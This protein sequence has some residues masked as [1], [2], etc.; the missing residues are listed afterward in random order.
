MVLIRI[1]ICCQCQFKKGESDSSASSE[2]SRRFRD[3]KINSDK[4]PYHIRICD[5]TVLEI[6]KFKLR[7]DE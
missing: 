2:L 1:K 7:T 3:C 6:C 4:Y 5:V